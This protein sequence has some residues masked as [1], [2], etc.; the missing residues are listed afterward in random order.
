MEKDYPYFVEV[1]VNACPHCGRGQMWTVIGPDGNC[2]GDS[3]G[4]DD[5]EINAGELAEMLNDAYY[6]GKGKKGKK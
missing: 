3:F 1:D 5:G 2:V 4:G 6:L